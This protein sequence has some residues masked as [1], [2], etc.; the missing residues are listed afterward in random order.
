M[1]APT[2]QREDASTLDSDVA[3]PKESFIQAGSGGRRPQAAMASFPAETGEMSHA[4]KSKT[5]EQY[6][7]FCQQAPEEGKQ[8][9]TLYTAMAGP[10]LG[11]TGFL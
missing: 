3:R 6:I 4:A 7:S 10:A 5:W 1:P 2:G 9:V 11:I 8:C